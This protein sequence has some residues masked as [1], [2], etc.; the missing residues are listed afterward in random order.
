MTRRGDEDIEGGLRKFLDIRKGGSEKMR[1]GGSENLYTLNPKGGGLLKN[2]TASEGTTKVSISSSPPP[3]YII[4]SWM[5]TIHLGIFRGWALWAD[6]VSPR[7]N[8]IVS[9]DQ[10]KPVKNGRKFSR[11]L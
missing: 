3:C 10:F 8:T 4:F 2:C 7:M 9:C 11:E 1:G 5:T 6:S